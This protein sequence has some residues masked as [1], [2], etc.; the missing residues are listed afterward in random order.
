MHLYRYRPIN[1]LLFKELLYDE[2]YPADYQELNDPVDLNAEIEFVPK[3]PESI[4]WLLHF[5]CLFCTQATG[6]FD[7]IAMLGDKVRV[8]AMVE[9]LAEKFA[10]RKIWSIEL[11]DVMLL[12]VY[13]K[14]KELFSFLKNRKSI[15][16]YLTE[17]TDQFA[18]N[19]NV[20]CF[21]RTK[22]NSLMW[23]HY[24]GGHNGICVEFD[25]KKKSLD[26][27]EIRLM[28]VSRNVNYTGP[29]TRVE[30]VEEVRRVEYG[31]RPRLNFFDFLPA[32]Y[33]SNDIDLKTIS[34]DRWRHYAN[35]VSTLYLNKG[36]HWKYEREWRLVQVGFDRSNLG[37]SKL[38]NYNPRFL[39]AVY[40]GSRVTPADRQR[41]VRLL[42]KEK[43]LRTKY[44]EES[45][46]SFGAMR[47]N[48]LEI[49]EE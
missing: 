7:G 37:E 29:N 23:S 31:L 44:Y 10:E 13:E 39:S 28:Y 11:L 3:E 2:L 27:C 12:S 35:R 36:L 47:F 43:G 24:A 40:F 20:V 30:Y 16:E 5:L 18:K 6:E 22:D 45:Y 48:L 46:D 19:S 8:S 1:A 25:L 38:L 34:K 49:D 26:T 21:S 4:Y 14:N 9:V 15:L 32:I 17:R 42:T 33:E 41:I